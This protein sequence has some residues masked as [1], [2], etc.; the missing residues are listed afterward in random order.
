LLLDAQAWVAFGVLAALEVVLGFDNVIVLAMLVERLPEDSR[1]SARLFGLALALLMRLALLFSVTW[2]T[3]LA[4]P[5][6]TLAGIGLSWRSLVLFGGGALLIAGS[7]AEIRESTGGRHAA[8][9]PRAVPGFWLVVLQIGL[10]DLLFSVDTVF[11]AVGVVTRIEVMVAAI[12]FAIL[13][14]LLLSTW[15]GGLIRRHPGLK[16]IGLWLLVVI[17]ASL[18]AESLGWDV[19]KSWLYLAMG[20]VSGVGWLVIM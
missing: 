9:L 8:R 6:V 11:T 7:L 19:P 2:L 1:R 10:L 13:A 20:L 17:G 4:R 14:M 18:V 15:V 16:T 5:V 12:V 3:T